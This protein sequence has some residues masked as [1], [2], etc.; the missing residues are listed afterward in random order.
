LNWDP[1]PLIVALEANSRHPIARA[2]RT[3]FATP[4][5][6]LPILSNHREI[7]GR[8]IEA[9]WNG[10]FYSLGAVE[11]DQVIAQTKE[12]ELALTHVGLYED[13]RM[14]GCVTLGD[15]I[16]T[17]APLVISR[18]LGLGIRPGILSGDSK[19]AVDRIARAV[20]LLNHPVIDSATPEQKKGSS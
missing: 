18:I 20:S 7:P 5:Q 15:P 10:R 6:K 4:D 9:E 14:L 2:L 16:R 11:N 19:P 3:H 1:A 8:G 13:G 17:E 12:N